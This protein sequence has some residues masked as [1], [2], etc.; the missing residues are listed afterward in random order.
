MSEFLKHHPRRDLAGGL[1]P[2]Y[3]FIETLKLVRAGCFPEMDLSDYEPILD[4]G[5]GFGHVVNRG[6][7]GGFDIWGTDIRDIYEFQRERF[8]Q[9]DSTIRIPFEDNTFGMIFESLFL[10]DL[11]S[12]QELDDA[13][14]QGVVEE[15]KRVIRVGGLV[16]RDGCSLHSGYLTRNG[17]RI[18][19]T[20]KHQTHI[21]R[22]EGN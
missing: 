21:Y 10:D 19:Y 9:G 7:E 8:R 14:V 18:Q 6:L 16:Y 15:M 17:F 13:K 22:W 12:L 2:A 20:D 5:C 3:K 1:C 4:L 11:I